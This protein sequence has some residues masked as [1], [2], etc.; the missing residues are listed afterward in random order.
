MAVSTGGVQG[1]ERGQYDSPAWEPS[2]PPLTQSRHPYNNTALCLCYKEK[3]SR[4]EREE[5][6][7]T[8]ETEEEGGGWENRRQ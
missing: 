8:D 5:K 1:A 6:E 2:S 7:D 3:E 4:G